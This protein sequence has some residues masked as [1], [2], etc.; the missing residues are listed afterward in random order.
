MASD[1]T[2]DPR[3]ASAE[4]ERRD[5]LRRGKLLFEA[6]HDDDGVVSLEQA[7]NRATAFA[8]VAARGQFFLDQVRDNV[9]VGL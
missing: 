5:A 8:E 9:A 2:V 6:I 1:A 4:H 3:V 7:E